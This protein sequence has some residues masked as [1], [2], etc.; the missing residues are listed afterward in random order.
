MNRRNSSAKYTALFIYITA[1]TAIALSFSA[2]SNDT[3]RTVRQSTDSDNT[4]TD[5]SGTETNTDGTKGEASPHPAVKFNDE[6]F[7]FLCRE[8]GAGAWTI[9]D[10][11]TDSMK[12][13]ILNDTIY[14]RNNKT[15]EECGVIINQVLSNNVT[16]EV[17]NSVYAGSCDY[18][19]IITNSEMNVDLAASSCLLNMNDMPEIDFTNPWWDSAANENLSLFGKQFY[20]ISDMNIMAFDATWI[21]MANITVLDD[22]GIKI[23]DIYETVRQGAWTLDKYKEV[24]DLNCRDVNNNSKTDSEDWYGTVMQ[25]HGADGFLIGC[26]V[27]FIDRQEDGVLS[28]VPL[29]ETYV[30][31]F[32]K[33]S[34]IINKNKAFNSHDSSQNDMYSRDTEY[35][36]VIFS[37]NRAIFFTETL[38]CVRRLR[39]METSFGLI[40]MPKADESQEHYI[41]MIH[42]WATSMLSVPLNAPD[43]YKSAVILEYMSWL[44]SETVKPVYYDIVIRDKYLRD[45]TSSEMLDYA[46]QERVIDLGHILLGDSTIISKIRT[47]IYD[48]NTAYASAYAANEK[49]VN[50]IIE[51]K[52]KDLID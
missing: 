34:S 11:Y 24:S 4:Q 39:E 28:L 2:C 20:A 17:K 52:F 51:R 46:M 31:I 9:L 36:Q 3:G 23:D 1:M 6:T 32:D 50:K 10:A 5:I 15:T 26:G 16:D 47:M 14:E 25:G 42:W 35:G 13:E 18:D 33:I 30:T 7:N 12:G 27:K 22:L 43:T 49:S 44:S 8:D 29:N 38:Q 45:A 40:P 41:S 48:G 37:E 21:T 19:A